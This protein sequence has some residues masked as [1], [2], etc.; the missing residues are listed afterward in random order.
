MA[1]TLRPSHKYFQNNIITYIAF[2]LLLFM[3]NIALADRN[4][5]NFD[6]P[7]PRTSGSSGGSRLKL[8]LTKSKL[9]VINRERSLQA[10]AY[11]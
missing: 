5:N 8:A 11:F 4:N 6:D 3:P 1:Q 9:L 2:C 7:P 10:I